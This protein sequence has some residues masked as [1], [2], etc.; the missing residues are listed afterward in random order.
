MPNNAPGRNDP[1]SCGSGKKYKKCCQS[2]DQARGPMVVEPHVH[3]HDADP[4][5]SGVG[6]LRV[7]DGLTPVQRQEYI[8]R[9]RGW[10]DT[11][12]DALDAGRLDEA[13][14]VAERLI[15]E[16]P[17]QIDGYE[18]RAMVRVHQ[19]RWPEAAA[20]FEQ[21]LDVVLRHPDDYDEGFIE[22]LRRDTDHARKHAQGHDWDSGPSPGDPFTHRHDS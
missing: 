18:V 21:A 19:K 17:D 2:H 1:C 3:A 8:E 9:L 15:A 22:A 16:Y 4:E 5:Y 6:V 10:A 14:S 13:D 20:G 11:A 7:P 12:R